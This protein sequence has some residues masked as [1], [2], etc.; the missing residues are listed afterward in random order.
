MGKKLTNDKDVQSTQKSFDT[1]SKIL[2]FDENTKS[3]IYILDDGYE[4]GF[5][6]WVALPDGRRARIVCGGGMEGKGFDPTNCKICNYLVE[7]YREAR[8]LEAEDPKEA[9]KMRKTLNQ[10]RA[11]YSAEFRAVKGELL[12]IKDPKTGA[13]TLSPDFD[14]YVVGILALTEPQFN[15]LIALVGSDNYPWMKTNADLLNR[16]LILDKRKR[17][18]QGK[19][20]KFPSV[21]FQPLK[22]QSDLPKIEYDKDELDTTKDFE[23]DEEKIEKAFNLLNGGGEYEDEEADEE[24][25]YENEDGDIEEEEVI[26][27]D[28]IVEEEVIEDDDSGND[29]SDIEEEVIEDDDF[30][31]DK[32]WEEEPKKSAPVNKKNPSTS[33]TPV[34]KSI[35]VK[36]SKRKVKR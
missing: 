12:K 4:E 19:D 31:D 33:K 25:G 8:A 18:K 23:I 1:N 22:N 2:K 28:E 34:K 17:N 24:I 7:G 15:S 30:E 9:D 5:V 3:P 21:E 16:V 26:E 14:E 29:L 27:E 6:H 10:M 11:N 35:P 36:T 20:A 32:P 13:K